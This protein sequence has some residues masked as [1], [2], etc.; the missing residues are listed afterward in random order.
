[1]WAPLRCTHPFRDNSLSIETRE[2]FSK[3][4]EWRDTA[5]SGDEDDDNKMF[6]RGSTK[7]QA[8]LA[9]KPF[10]LGNWKDVLKY[11]TTFGILSLVHINSF[12]LAVPPIPGEPLGEY[13]R[14]LGQRAPQECS[15]TVSPDDGHSTSSWGNFLL[16]SSI[17]Y[18]LAGAFS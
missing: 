16:S 10:C 5:R 17:N 3:A 2:P 7:Q 15:Q 11:P 13:H 1:M 12:S 18:L 4:P 9:R 14:I 6:C 8:E